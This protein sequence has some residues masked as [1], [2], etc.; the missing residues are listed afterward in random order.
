MMIR[1]RFLIPM[2][3]LLSVI[4]CSCTDST[5]TEVKDSNYHPIHK[6]SFVG[7]QTC[8]ECH[9][10]EYNDWI[11]SHH[12]Q[13]MKIA[14]DSTVLGDFNNATFEHFGVKY[15][16]YKENGN[17]MVK[18]EDA[19]GKIQ[20]YQVKYTFGFDPLQQYIVTIDGREQMLPTSW[21]ADPKKDEEPHWF[22]LYPDEKIEP[23]DMLHW[24]STMQNWNYMC[25][26]C[27]STN[28]HKNFDLKSNSFAT[29]WNEINVSCEA[30]HGPSSKHNLW[31]SDSLKYPF[32][33]M[34]LVYK[35][36]EDTT[37]WVWDME[38]GS[39]YRAKPRTDF[40]QIEMCGR[41]HSRRSQ[42]SE[43]YIWGE[44]L[45][46]THRVEL[47][48][49]PTYYSDG[50]ILDEDYVYA[51]FLQSK[52]YQHGV[53]CTNC[54]DPHTNKIKSNTNNLCL[55]C[56]SA[57]KYDSKEHHFHKMDDTGANCMDCHM[58][59]TNYM[60]T[61]PR[62]DHSIRNPRPDLSIELGVPNSCTQCH[63]D[64]TDEWALDSMKKWY[65]TDWIKPH[66]GHTLHAARKGD[67]AALDSLLAL[68]DNT[69]K[70]NIIRAT[71]LGEL[72]NYPLT[73]EFLLKT[74]AKHQT[75]ANEMIRREAASLLTRLPAEQ[76]LQAALPFFSDDVKVVRLEA[77]IA[78][79]NTPMAIEQEETNETLKKGIE[80]YMAS[81]DW[82]T[83]RSESHINKAQMYLS[84]GKLDLAEW[85][86][87]E[88]LRLEPRSIFVYLNWAD[89]YRAQNNETR[90]QELLQ[91]AIELQSDFAPAHLALGLSYVRLKQMDKAL[92][93]LEKAFEHAADAHPGYVYAV[94]LFSSEKQ[95]KGV[96]VLEKVHEKFPYD[97]AV[98]EGLVSFCQTTRQGG[99][100]QKYQQK[101]NAVRSRLR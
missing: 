48:N 4:Y 93:S 53:T 25:A 82:N 63:D 3:G 80:E 16:F 39:S 84:R 49:A 52:M 9:E 14:N 20:V 89:L 94:A 50:Q 85:E 75:N 98:L 26:E 61:D 67:P 31:A 87:K 79:L 58:P 13:A 47:L 96:E 99:K 12:E 71:A 70:T 38:K 24:T 77:V 92:A 81:L 56:H 33:N 30:C 73:P 46:Q 78:T 15:E 43:H 66:H 74:I 10:K 40:T 95:A 36:K 59:T 69:S 27:H 35:L 18:A 21:G 91:K 97:L 5:E 57:T 76:R 7:G 41:C 51:S 23:N 83:E 8:I 34:G 88:A 54:H 19:N 100:L 68:I 11:G 90:S 64:K 60:V 45:A 29:T 72:R 62:R 22:H 17:Y 55:Q 28:L 86:Y 101:L 65:G 2:L 32:D 6:A 42:I 37:A 1:F 44:P